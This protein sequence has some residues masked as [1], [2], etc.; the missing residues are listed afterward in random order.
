MRGDVDEGRDLHIRS[1]ET[2]RE[3]GLLTGAA[4]ASMARGR[5][6]ERAGDLEAAE[7]FLREGMLELERLNDRA[8][9]STV[10]VNLA[11]CVYEQGRL[12]ETREI[13]AL[14]REITADDDVT[15]LITLGFLEGAVLAHEG[16]LGD[17]EEMGRGAV[18]LSDTTDHFFER[19]N[20]R[21][22]LASTH[23]RAG[24]DDEAAA[25]AREGL[26]IIEAKGGVTGLAC[27]RRLLAAA[28]AAIDV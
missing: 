6:E 24:R 9:R 18:D 1:R 10:V 2:I 21:L 14:A 11:E 27:G 4:G 19:A 26:G 8:Y 23:A 7:H 16:R 25:L 17:A 5:I 22:H 3:A 28:D 20:A 12:D 13:C 15:N